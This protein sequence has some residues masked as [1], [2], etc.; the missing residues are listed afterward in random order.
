LNVEILGIN[1][2]AYQA[3]SSLLTANS[4][5]PLLQDTATN[6]VWSDW[7]ANYD[8]VRILDA[9]NRLRAVF[10]LNTHSLTVATNRAALKALF[11]EAAKAVDTDGDHLLDDWEEAYWGNL[12]AKPEEDPDADGVDNASEFAFGSNP[13][14]PQSRPAPLTFTVRPGT[15]PVL[16]LTFR[17]QV[18]SMLTYLVEGSTD[19]ETWTGEPAW[20]G[21]LSSLVNQFDG[22]GVA[23]ATWD[24]TPPPSAATRGFLRLRAQNRP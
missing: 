2:T 12:A 9:R 14:D 23:V 19:L 3:Y 11:L 24:S 15:T 18:G 21:S 13:T 4:H 1:H 16:D 5:L 20:A 17:R 22:T 7:R 8:D 6:H 10:N